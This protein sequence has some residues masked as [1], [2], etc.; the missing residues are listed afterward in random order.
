LIAAFL[1][2]TRI[3]TAQIDLQQRADT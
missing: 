1:V 3:L 2:Q